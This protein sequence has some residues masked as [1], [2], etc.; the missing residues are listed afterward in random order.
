MHAR[1]LVTFNFDDHI[2]TSFGP[3]SFPTSYYFEY[4]HASK[5]GLTH[6]NTSQHMSVQSKPNLPIRDPEPF[7][8]AGSRSGF[9][10]ES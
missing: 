2:E 10:N 5:V 1:S 9:L 8:K 4:W 3:K 7:A 6:A